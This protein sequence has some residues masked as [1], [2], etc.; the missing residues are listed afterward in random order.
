M[1]NYFE[2]INVL[3]LI[4]FSLNGFNTLLRFFSK[5]IITGCHGTSLIF[6][7]PLFIPFLLCVW[8]NLQRVS[9]LNILSVS[10][11]IMYIQFVVQPLVKYLYLLVFSCKVELLFSS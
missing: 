7:I 9:I 6:F 3:F 10:F 2:T 4:R 5:L 11:S 1:E 8:L